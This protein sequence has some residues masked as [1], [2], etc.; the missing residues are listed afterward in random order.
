MLRV[1]ITHSVQLVIVTILSQ[2][3]IAVILTAHPSIIAQSALFYH[4]QKSTAL[5][6][7][8]VTLPHPEYAKHHAVMAT[9]LEQRRVAMM[10]IQ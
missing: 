3:I 2:A 7:L 1:I 10:E 4:Q 8:R 6:A 5:C 9:I